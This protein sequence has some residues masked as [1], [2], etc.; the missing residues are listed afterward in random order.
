MTE[1]KTLKDFNCNKL[2]DMIVSMNKDKMV[3]KQ[4]LKKEAIR[5]I[6]EWNKPLIDGEMTTRDKANEVGTKTELF[7]EFFNLT[8]GDFS[9]GCK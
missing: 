3:S 2:S 1:L 4:D 6:K 9:D 7:I 8:E 5:R